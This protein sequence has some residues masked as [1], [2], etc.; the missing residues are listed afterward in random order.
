MVHYLNQFFAQIG[1]EDKADLPPSAREGVIGP[2]QAF[3]KEFGDQAEIVTTVYCGDS[4]FAEH[5]AKAQEK[6]VK[7]IAA[8]QP[9]V[10]L[11]GPAFNAGRY[12]MACGAV[13]QGVA[14]RLSIPVVGGLFPEN[15]GYEM[16]R[17]YAFFVETK[18]SAVGMREAV[19][20]MAR[21][22][23]KLARG[24]EIGP[25]AE[26]GYLPRGCR[27][28]FFAPE[29]GAKRAVA[30]LLRKMAGLPFTTEY[31]MPEFD[32][33]PP[34]KNLPDAGQAL[35]ALVTSGGIVPKGNP[36]RI[37][38]SSAGR[39]ASY[40]LA[41]VTDLSPDQYQTVHGGYDPTYA[42]AD[43]DRVL[44]VDA[45]RALEK[46]GRIGSLYERYFVTVG[47]GTSV[48]NAARFAGE[49]AQAL[50]NDGVQAVILTST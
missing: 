21:L 47:N 18:G 15:P 24:E 4:Y 49:I 42:N 41:G 9:D 50:K 32:R 19:P 48:A 20:R 2:G 14:Q 5:I 13:A 1:G 34:A 39:Y 35:V 25:P 8:A 37:P 16:Y 26:E 27:K 33:V 36:D 30:M 40:S 11:V 12:G 38:A 31:P 29:S 3:A 10:V 43:P 45:A 23:L 44:P 6:C 17:Q 28:N 46:E 7:L 22:A